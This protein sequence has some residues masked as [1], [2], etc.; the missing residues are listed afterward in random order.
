M[1]ASQSA[2][3]GQASLVRVH[4]RDSSRTRLS[5]LWWKKC[6]SAS[7]GFQLLHT[8]FSHLLHDP[9]QHLTP[10]PAPP[11]PLLLPVSPPSWVE[12]GRWKGVGGLCSDELGG[13]PLLRCPNLTKVWDEALRTDPRLK[14]S[15]AWASGL[16]IQASLHPLKTCLAV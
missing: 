2:W 6:H 7:G 11:R 12:W 3:Q 9:P 16:K 4:S 15:W 5:T 13:D 1:R 8:R 10:L 14:S